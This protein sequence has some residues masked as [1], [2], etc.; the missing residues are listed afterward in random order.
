MAPA[1]P[2]HR[3]QRRDAL[4]P[5]VSLQRNGQSQFHLVLI[6]SA[7]S[8]V[9]KLRDLREKRAA[10]VD[11]YSASGYVIPDPARRARYRSAH[12]ILGKN[13]FC[14]HEEVVRAVV[15][16]EAHFGATYAG[17]DASGSVVRGPWLS[18]AG[19]APGVSRVRALYTFRAIP[20]DVVAA[21]RDMPERTRE[22]V[23][24]AFIA[25]SRAET[26]APLLREIFGIQRGAAV[27]GRRLRAIA[28]RRH[29]GVGQRR[30]AEAREHG[31]FEPAG[32]PASAQTS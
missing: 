24:A 28:H 31:S 23:T 8:P 16:G 27:V 21:H 32:N 18:A 2:V 7:A 5:L 13:S 12:G 6:V 20:G 3:A 9:R 19:A 14:T 15:E 4:A 30:A 26:L 10:W 25:V 1:H 22:K 29:R 11:P 17:L